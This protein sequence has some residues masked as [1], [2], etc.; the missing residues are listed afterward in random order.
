MP[1][2]RI[3]L[4]EGRSIDID[5]EKHNAIAD[6]STKNQLARVDFY[7]SNNKVVA[8]FSASALQ[9]YAKIDNVVS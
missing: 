9:G 7:D 1:K 4:S 3:Y 6:A 5:A 2:Y 8:S